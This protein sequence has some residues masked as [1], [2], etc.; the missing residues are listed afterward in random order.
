[1]IIHVWEAG[2]WR[3][4]GRVLAKQKDL[5]SNPASAT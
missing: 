4:K 1:M 3:R 2:E 5:G